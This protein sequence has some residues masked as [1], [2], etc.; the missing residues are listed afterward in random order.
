VG[1]IVFRRRE[2]GVYEFSGQASLGRILAGIVSIKAGM[3]PTG[4]EPVLEWRPHF[5]LTGRTVT[6]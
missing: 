4:F 2:N 3:A 1:R 5:R 6:S